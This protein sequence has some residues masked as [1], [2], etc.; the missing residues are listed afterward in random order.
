MK[1]VLRNKIGQT[2]ECKIGF[3]WTNLF[4]GWL[5]PL[6]RGDYKNFA[7]QLVVQLFTFSISVLVFPF[8]Y[9]KQYING[10]LEKN[11]YPINEESKR[12][13][14]ENGFL[15]AENPEEIN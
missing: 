4:F 1:V 3:S 15:L 13:L 7:I 12:I 14:I 10:L 2:K 6:F 9:N 5:T 11:F 8:F